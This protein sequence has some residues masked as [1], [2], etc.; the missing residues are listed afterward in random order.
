MGSM[1]RFRLDCRRASRES[2][3]NLSGKKASTGTG[4]EVKRRSRDE[5]ISAAR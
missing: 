3:E 2:R 1:S 5:G 4:R